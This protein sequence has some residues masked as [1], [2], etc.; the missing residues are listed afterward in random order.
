MSMEILACGR[1]AVGSI[2]WL[3]LGVIP[4]WVFC[5]VWL[6]CL[7]VFYQCVRILVEEYRERKKR[8]SEDKQRNGESYQPLT[9]LVG[10][11]ADHCEDTSELVQGAHRELRIES[12][13]LGAR[14]KLLHLVEQLL[15]ALLK[16]MR[17]RRAH[18]PNET[19]LSHRWR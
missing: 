12:W 16:I 18:R 19:E 8:H 17:R 14:D 1:F 3:G 15:C 4:L 7:F 5:Y 2:A 9:V 6:S 10:G 13:I 11:E